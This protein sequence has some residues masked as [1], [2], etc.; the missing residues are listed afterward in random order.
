MD[1]FYK[2]ASVMPAI[3]YAVLFEKATKCAS[4]STVVNFSEEAEFNPSHLFVI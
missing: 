3:V 1:V 2:T 4:S